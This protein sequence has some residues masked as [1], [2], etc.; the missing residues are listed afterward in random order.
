[1][2]LAIVIVAGLL[3]HFRVFGRWGD[4]AVNVLL[5]TAAARMVARNYFS[6]SRYR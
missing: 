2:S 5:F 3:V 1:M 6:A 4:I